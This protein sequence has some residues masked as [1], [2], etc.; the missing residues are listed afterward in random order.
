L[1]GQR[2]FEFTTPNSK[3]PIL[4]LTVKNNILLHTGAGNAFLVLG[5]TTTVLANFI[6]ENNIITDGN[7]GMFGG[8]VGSGT[9]ALTRYADGYSYAGNVQI[10]RLIDIN[11]SYDLS[12]FSTNYPV[13]N[14]INDGTGT[15]GFIDLANANY[16]LAGSSPYKN[17]GTDGK[18]P[19]PNWDTLLASTANTT[20]GGGAY[21]PPQPQTCTSFT[22]SDWGACQSNSTH[23]RTTTSSS[24]Q[25]CT[26]G[27]PILSESCT[28]TPQD[29]PTTTCTSFTYS[30]WGTCQSNNA[31]TRTVA[32]QSPTNCTGGSPILSQSCTYVANTTDTNTNTNTNTNTPTTQDNSVQIAQLLAKIAELRA[33]ISALLAQRTTSIPSTFKFTTTL[34]LGQNSNDVKYLQ[35]LL[36]SDPDT[37]IATTGYGSPGYE[38]IHFGP[39]TK[40]A[41]IKFQTKYASDISQGKALTTGAGLAGPATRAK[42]NAVLGR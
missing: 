41:L 13:N 4:D 40:Q 20:T 31:R 19:G 21:I 37:K 14:F 30:D 2:G 5:D 29:T 34:R 11:Y 32:T 24:P 10:T 35:I 1:G 7:Y 26:G 39:S 9:V 3:Y 6:F 23:T 27:T 36:N 42:L 17:A 33:Q 38:T 8:S 15:V 16:R 25:G 28:Y 22:Y 12:H 18:D